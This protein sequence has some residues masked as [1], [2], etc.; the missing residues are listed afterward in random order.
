M[1]LSCD[2][3]VV[4]EGQLETHCPL[5]RKNPGRHAVHCNWSTVDAAL[6]FGSWHL[7]QDAPQ[8]RQKSLK[9][10]EYRTHK[11]KTHCRIHVYYCPQLS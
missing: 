5:L 10:N 8:A 6:K 4:P 3:T 2:E 1:R 11:W 9:L 7:V